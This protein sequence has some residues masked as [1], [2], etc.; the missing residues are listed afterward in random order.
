MM[1]EVEISQNRGKL[2]KKERER[3]GGELI[4]KGAKGKNLFLHFWLELLFFTAN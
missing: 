4:N 3:G 1:L 2:G